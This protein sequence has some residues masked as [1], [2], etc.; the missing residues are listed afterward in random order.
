MGTQT[1]L[2]Y[3]NT[4]LPL[5]YDGLREVAD[6]AA[7][8]IYPDPEGAAVYTSGMVRALQTLAVMYGADPDRAFVRMEDIYPQHRDNVQKA[9]EKIT[10]LCRVPHMTEPLLREINLGSYEMM[11][12]GEVLAD[13]YGR[14]WLEGRLEDPQFD[15]GDS[16]SGFDKRV[17]RGIHNVISESARRGDE[18]MIVVIHGGVIAQLLQNFFPGTYSNLWDW[19]P[20]PGTGYAIT[21]IDGEPQSWKPVGETGFRVVPMNQ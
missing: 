11:T 1:D 13:D 5:T 16:M 20:E 2:M 15:G 8:G 12:I 6:Y 4:E 19:T 18:R 3:G 17:S 10:A 21:L 7:E 14:D 9:A